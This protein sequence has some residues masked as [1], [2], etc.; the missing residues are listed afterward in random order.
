MRY[1]LGRVAA[2][3]VEHP[4]AAVVLDHVRRPQVVSPRGRVGGQGERLLRPRPVQRRRGGVGEVDLVERRERLGVGDADEVPRALV[5][6]DEGVVVDVPALGLAD[7]RVVDE[8]VLADV[9]R[10]LGRVGHRPA[11]LGRGPSAADVG[12]DEAVDV[13]ELLLGLRDLVGREDGVDRAL[14]QAGVARRALVGVDVE[15]LVAVEELEVGVGR[16][17]VG[18]L[19]VLGS[20]G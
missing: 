6:A 8:L 7:R 11:T 17:G 2:R 10:G 3:A 5:V 1:G 14:G 13:D 16:V 18:D 15:H 4:V 9:E 19:P 20:R 12:E